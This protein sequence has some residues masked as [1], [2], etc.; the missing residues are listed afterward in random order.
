EAKSRNAVQLLIGGTEQFFREQPSQLRS[1]FD[2]AFFVEVLK[3]RIELVRSTMAGS[4]DAMGWMEGEDSPRT[5]PVL[6]PAADAE[7]SGI[8]RR[9]AYNYVAACHDRRLQGALLTLINGV[10]VR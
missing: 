2:L 1:H 7:T 3:D 5:H 8:R 9:Q 4:V 6:D 10:V